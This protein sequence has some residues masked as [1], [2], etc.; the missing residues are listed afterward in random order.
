MWLKLWVQFDN[1]VMN[2]TQKLKIYL[3]IVKRKRCVIIDMSE[4]RINHSP[5]IF[6]C[7]EC[8]INHYLGVD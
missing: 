6:V 7:F 3:L 8:K 5:T 1:E 4:Q 2:G